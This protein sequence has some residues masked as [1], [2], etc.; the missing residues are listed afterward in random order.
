MCWFSS[1]DGI[2]LEVCGMDS[3][4]LAGAQ[5]L[6]EDASINTITSDLLNAIVSFS[7]DTSIT[8]MDPCI[9]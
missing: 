6:R 9:R 2:G 4:K 1:L 8:P 5:T 3:R 7:M